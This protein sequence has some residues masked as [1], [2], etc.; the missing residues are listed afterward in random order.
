MSESKKNSCFGKNED[1]VLEM[2]I[3]DTLSSV[4][5]MNSNNG[6]RYR[7]SLSCLFSYGKFLKTFLT[8]DCILLPLDARVVQN[9]H[10]RVSFHIVILFLRE[11]SL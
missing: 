9:V 4:D 3:N 6:N 11:A 1:Y 2:T 10:G 7:A 8:L 5:I